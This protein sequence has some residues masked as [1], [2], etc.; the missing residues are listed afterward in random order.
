MASS[1]TSSAINV[2]V[3]FNL[4]P[5]IDE[6]VSRNGFV[7]CRDRVVERYGSFVSSDVINY[8]ISPFAWIQDNANS[9]SF[10]LVP[11]G[12]SKSDIVLHLDLP[13]SPSSLEDGKKHI[14][15]VCESPLYCQGSRLLKNQQYFDFVLTYEASVNTVVHQPSAVYGLP[16]LTVPPLCGVLHRDEEIRLDL[17]SREKC[18]LYIGANKN[19]GFKSSFFR[20]HSSHP[21]LKRLGWL[22]CA[23]EKWHDDYFY[24]AKIQRY[25]MLTARRR[26]VSAFSVCSGN[27]FGIKVLGS[28]W[29]KYSTW[30]RKMLQLPPSSLV[31]GG[32]LIPSLPV[33][34]KSD[35]LKSSL[36]SLCLENARGFPGY[37]T[38]KVFD[39][40]HCGCIPVVKPCN[41]IA[42]YLPS[43]CYVN[44]DNFNSPCEL[45]QFLKLLTIDEL[46]VL[47]TSGRR[48]IA[49]QQYFNRFSFASF[50][51]KLALAVRSLV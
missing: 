5:H 27:D 25:E 12:C 41:G 24:V 13:E 40:L 9:C 21:L 30:Y 23:P 33:A 15:C 37:V 6:Y 1:P 51:S 29:E 4:Y 47:R 48:F 2:E 14:L 38:E 49:S 10:C 31:L 45:F 43:D 22:G 7:F 34:Q 42:D 28:G 20:G 3:R 36:F 50:A 11:R 46:I 44:I 8:W 18:L 16:F 32:Q 39:A 17:R 26:L 35:L 19:W